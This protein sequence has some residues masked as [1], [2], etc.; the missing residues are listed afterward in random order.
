M[1]LPETLTGITIV[2]VAI[3]IL[4]ASVVTATRIDAE[5]A[6]KTGVHADFTDR[7][8]N[9][10]NTY[11]SSDIFDATNGLCDQV[12]IADADVGGESIFMARDTWRSAS[13]TL[14]G[15]A[16]DTVAWTQE[17]PCSIQ[18]SAIA[19]SRGLAPFHLRTPA[20]NVDT[21]D[22][23]T[24]TTY[25]DSQDA[26]N[27]VRVMATVPPQPP[28]IT[29][30]EASFVQTFRLTTRVRIDVDVPWGVGPISVDVES[31]SDEDFI[32]DRTDGPTSERPTTHTIHLR[33]VEPP[34]DFTV[35]ATNAL[36]TSEVL[37]HLPC[38]KDGLLGR[39][40]VST[41]DCQRVGP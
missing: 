14:G 1:T 17:T 29:Q 28:V 37:V 12:S 8:V 33:N 31:T 20:V 18:D 23:S 3:A 38:P 9:I 13:L 25:F 16:R 7:E 34:A 32:I 2:L 35:K 15:P 26:P 4:V 24:G 36:G 5:Q 19:A 39:D 30:A 11:L 40:G 41:V 27:L 6:F 21:T 10:L 22:F